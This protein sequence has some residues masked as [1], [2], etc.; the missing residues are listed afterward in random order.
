MSA[1]QSA[2]QRV[3]ETVGR[4]DESAVVSRAGQRAAKRA[5]DLASR[6]AKW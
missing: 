5:D 6:M 1:A 3:Y 4:W 2:A